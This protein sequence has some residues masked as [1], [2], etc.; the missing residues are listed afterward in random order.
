MPITIRRMEE[1]DIDFALEQTA[2]EGWDIPVGG[3]EMHLR[4]D[5]EGC[6]IAERDGD[7]VAMITS[8]RYADLAFIGNLI[9]EPSSR[10]QGIGEMLMRRAMDCL[11]EQGIS[12]L[13]LE[14]DPPG[15]KLYRKLGF[16]DAFESL[17]F[18]ALRP[19]RPAASGVEDV[20][21]LTGPD[22]A[23]I[24]RFDARHFG[25][26]R[27]PLLAALLDRAPAA[28]RT[29][30]DGE[31]SGYVLTQTLEDGVRIGPAVAVDRRASTALL[32]AVL[33]YLNAPR[34]TA[35]LPESNQAGVLLLRARGFEPKPSCRRMVHGPERYHGNP[36][37]V[38]AV[39]G[40]DRG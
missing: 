18:E 15:V 19:A 22:L 25:S 28:F 23:T 31:V 36:R 30:C 14:A 34:F 29:P 40:G 3:F 33:A 7:R 8:T 12:R 24:A 11:W 5:P 10:R 17:R 9:V 16:T 26:D 4:D 27:S 1:R 20:Q 38:L 13:A 6:F 21:P 37:H 39:A 2:R 32:E 35:G